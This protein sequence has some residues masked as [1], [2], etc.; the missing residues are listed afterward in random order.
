MKTLCGLY[1]SWCFICRVSFDLFGSLKGNA[2]FGPFAGYLVRC[3]PIAFF[4]TLCR[5]VLLE[6]QCPS[7]NDYITMGLW[8]VIGVALVAFGVHLVYKYENSYAKII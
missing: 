1:C 5:K 7:M 2:T 8:A 4:S 6:Q 3:N